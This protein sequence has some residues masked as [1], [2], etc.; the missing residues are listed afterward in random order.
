MCSHKH[1]TIVHQ[2]LYN[3]K[4]I[5]YK[6]TG[7]VLKVGP[8]GRPTRP[9]VLCSFSSPWGRA[10]WGGKC[11]KTEG[12]H[13]WACHLGGSRSARTLTGSPRWNLGP[14]TQGLTVSRS[15]WQ[16]SVTIV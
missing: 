14:R 4:G 13:L 15:Y 10:I 7:I 5:I 3:I 2:H 9:A 11:D 16:T 8:A 12:V 1:T 6:S